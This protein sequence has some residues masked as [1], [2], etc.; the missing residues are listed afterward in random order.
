[1]RASGC[2]SGGAARWVMAV[3]S[4]MTA[5]VGGNARVWLGQACRSAAWYFGATS[6]GY[7][8]GW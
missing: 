7:G 4:G 6:Y 2:G 1:M 5:E 3:E 8:A